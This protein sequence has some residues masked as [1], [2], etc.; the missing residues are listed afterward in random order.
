MSLLLRQYQIKRS[1][2]GKKTKIPF[3]FQTELVTGVCESCKLNTV[4][5]GI[6]S[7]FYRCVSCGEDLEQ[8]VNGVI[9]YIVANK[10]TRFRNPHV[11]EK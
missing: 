7:T 5:I 11:K 3:S 9:K 1:M 6:E 8:K 4:L 2:T 10:N